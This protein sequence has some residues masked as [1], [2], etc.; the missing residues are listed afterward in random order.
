MSYFSLLN[1]AVE[2]LSNLKFLPNLL[3][4]FL[5]ISAVDDYNTRG[6]NRRLGEAGLAPDSICEFKILLAS[7]FHAEPQGIES[8]MEKFF[9]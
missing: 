1:T 9:Y 3:F 6:D 5:N 4:R 7:K 2:Q 8:L